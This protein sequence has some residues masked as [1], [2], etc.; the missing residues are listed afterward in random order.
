M[1]TVLVLMSTYNGEKYIDEQMQSLLKQEEVALHILVRDDGSKD[2]TVERLRHW[3][4]QYPNRITTMPSPNIGVVRSFF[5]LIEQCSDQYDYYAFCD[6]D[7][8][9]L[10][11]KLIS[12][13]HKLKGQS[14]GSSELAHE[15]PLMY[16]STTQMT[17]ESLNPTKIWPP[18]PEKKLSPYNALIENVC[19]GCTML[20]NREAMLLIKQQMPKD[21][22]KVIMHDWWVYLS[23]SCFGEV[24]FDQNSYILYRQHQHNA[25]GGA[26][27]RLF[28]KWVKRV[29]RFIKGKNRYIL[30]RQADEFVAAFGARIKPTYLQDINNFLSAYRKGPVRRLQYILQTPFYRQS[31][32]DHLI[33][34]LVYIMGKL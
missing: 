18:M 6:Q 14:E 16:C 2:S 29:K 21:V 25:L 9:W 30:S 17:D 22:D 26:T 4:S 10:P 34:K 33:Y 20:M 19:V 15:R 12:A 28:S 32:S 3:E 31:A 8:V 27:D 24:V 23:V 1:Y 5:D 13:I 11:T 7:D